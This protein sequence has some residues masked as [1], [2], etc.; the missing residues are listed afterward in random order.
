[1]DRR[2]VLDLAR[3]LQVRTRQLLYPR[4]ESEADGQPS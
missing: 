1:M 3:G 2:G 4:G